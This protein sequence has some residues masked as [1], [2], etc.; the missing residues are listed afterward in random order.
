MKSIF[1]SA[2]IPVAGKGRG[3]FYK[4]ADI[5]L[6]KQAVREFLIVCLGRRHIVWGGH[7]AITPI[8]WAV[9]QDLGV[10][11]SHAVTLYQT[12]FFE[13]VFPE[14]NRHFSNVVF[15]KIV[16]GD[17]QGSLSLMRHAMLSRDD[18]YAAVFIGGMQ[19][20]NDEYSL[21]KH[22]HPRATI[23]PIATPGGAAKDLAVKINVD[24]DIL[25]E[26]NYFRLYHS[27]LNIDVNEKRI[28]GTK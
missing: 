13:D 7:P 23:L 15:T 11:Y 2:S 16:N 17:R 9:C 4:S 27:K 25:N 28:L 21:F 20:I 8:F 18:L 12:K 26:F 6:I 1:L 10:N 14:E 22:Y 5:Y 19:G 24:N 3:D